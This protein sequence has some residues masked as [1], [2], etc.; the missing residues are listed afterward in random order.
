MKFIMALISLVVLFSCHS[1]KSRSGAADS[2]VKI[3]AG[4]G[5]TYDSTR[6]IT[7]VV[8][9]CD[10]GNMAAIR[11]WTDRCRLTGMLNRQN[12]DFTLP[13]VTSGSG[14]RYSDG[15]IVVWNKGNEVFIDLGNGQTFSCVKKSEVRP[16]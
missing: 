15:K 8:F 10:S 13:Q 16:E 2:S 3:P 7:T 4:P 1:N 11:F 9:D 14:A 12:L 5:Q 6:P